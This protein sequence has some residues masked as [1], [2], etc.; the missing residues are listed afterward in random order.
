MGW[1]LVL[2]FCGCGWCLWLLLMG[3][4]LV[5]GF[6]VGVVVVWV[7][8]AVGFVVAV[9]FW[10]CGGEGGVEGVVLVGKGV[11][12]VDGLFVVGGIV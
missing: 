6:W 12:G 11:V 7:G 10:V 1:W 8:V 5:G 3:S 2:W 4:V 9:G